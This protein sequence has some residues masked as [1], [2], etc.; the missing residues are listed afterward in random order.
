MK[1]FVFVWGFRIDTDKISLKDPYEFSEEILNNSP[2]KYYDSLDEIS[3]DSDIEFME[4]FIHEPNLEEKKSMEYIEDFVDYLFEYDLITREIPISDW[5]V[6][7]VKQYYDDSSLDCCGTYLACDHLVIDHA[8]QH[9]DI[10]ALQSFLK[11]NDEINK[12]DA[13]T[14]LN[15]RGL[16]PLL[17][18]TIGFYQCPCDFDRN[19]EMF[20]I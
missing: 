18:N 7:I 12:N 20:R 2:E 1:N 13:N 11:N 5:Y 8:D 15:L 4:T 16:L 6:L 19:P 9:L 14:M 3:Y 10:N 17:D